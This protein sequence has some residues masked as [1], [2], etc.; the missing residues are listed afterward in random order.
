MSTTT[1]NYEVTGLT[2]G[3]C[4]ASVTEELS[5]LAGVDSVD[6]ELNKGG[7]SVVTVT[8]AAALDLDQVRAAIVEAGYEL[9]TTAP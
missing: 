9:V 1:Q 7:A 5:E 4:V 8:S 2:C 6:I 3:H